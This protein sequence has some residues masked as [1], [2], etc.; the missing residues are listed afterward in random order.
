MPKG[1]QGQTVFVV[2][3]VRAV[4]LPIVAMAFFTPVLYVTRDAHWIVLGWVASVVIT[5]LLLRAADKRGLLP[6]A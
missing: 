6:H 4:L 5:G 2:K 1:P 3:V